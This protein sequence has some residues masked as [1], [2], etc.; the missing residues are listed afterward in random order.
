MPLVLLWFGH[1]KIIPYKANVALVT[2]LMTLQGEIKPGQTV[3]EPALFDTK[4]ISAMK[5]PRRAPK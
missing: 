2:K 1:F 3:A 5:R 4:Y